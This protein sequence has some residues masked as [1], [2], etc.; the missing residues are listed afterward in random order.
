MRLAVQ[1]FVILSFAL[2]MS[3]LSCAADGSN[4]ANVIGELARQKVAA[5]GWAR[6]WKSR[7]N[8]AISEE[9]AYQNDDSVSSSYLKVSLHSCNLEDRYREFRTTYT[10][11]AAAYEGLIAQIRLAVIQSGDYEELELASSSRSAIYAA[12]AFI[13]QAQLAVNAPNICSKL[14]EIEVKE[15]LIGLLGETIEPVLNAILTFHERY[16]SEKAESRK[17]ILKEIDALRWVAVEEL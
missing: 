6:N 8:A 2:S 5:E 11:A 13:S 14:N 17:A 1:R 16:S 4:D 15:N 3:H 10:T 12:D 7:L 9:I